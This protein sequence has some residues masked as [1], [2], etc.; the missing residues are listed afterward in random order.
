L[1]AQVLYTHL[2]EEEEEEEE[3]EI[4]IQKKGKEMFYSSSLSTVSV[5]RGGGGKAE[6]KTT[7]TP[8]F[9]WVPTVRSTLHK[10]PPYLPRMGGHYDGGG[11]VLGRAVARREPGCIEMAR[12]T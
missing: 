7:K 6:N 1:I 12:S 2:G 9:G 3:E 10:V 11:G 4:F 5:S 8:Y